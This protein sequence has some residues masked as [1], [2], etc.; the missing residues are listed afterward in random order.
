MEDE[1]HE[2]CLS[3]LKILN[4]ELMEKHKLSKLST[5]KDSKSNKRLW[6]VLN[7]E[8]V[9]GNN[10]IKDDMRKENNI[11]NNTSINGSW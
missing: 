6:T 7:S 9:G 1:K 11:T 4:L 3:K 2:E 10:K 8:K 5:Q